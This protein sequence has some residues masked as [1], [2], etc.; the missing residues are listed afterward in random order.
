VTICEPPHYFQVAFDEPPHQPSTVLVDVIPADGDAHLILTHAGIH[1]G[2]LHT[3]DLLWTASL[4]RLGQ[5][6]AGSGGLTEGL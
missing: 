1:H 4:S 6:V 5:R 3:Y 2:L